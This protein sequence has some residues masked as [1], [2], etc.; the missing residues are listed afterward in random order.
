MAKRRQREK[1]RAEMKLKSQEHINESEE[2]EEHEEEISKELLT[3][4]TKELFSDEEEE[5]DNEDEEE[6]RVS[7]SPVILTNERY[8]PFKVREWKHPCYCR[9]DLMWC[10]RWQLHRESRSRLIDDLAF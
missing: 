8:N 9:S 2:T 10:C 5:K 7:A 1:E 3:D 6:V 4:Q